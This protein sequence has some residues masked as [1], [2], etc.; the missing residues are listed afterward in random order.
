MPDTGG[1]LILDP[2]DR[3]EPIVK[4]R[5]ALT[6]TGKSGK[7]NVIGWFTEC[8]GLTIE[9]EP[10]PYKEGG[11]NDFEHQ[12]PG[13]VKQSRVTLKRGLA[14][15]SLWDWFQ[16]GLY[17][18]KVERRNVSIILYNSDLTKKKQWDLDSA[19]PVKWTGPDFQ[20]DTNQ[21][22]VETLELVHH[23]LSMKDWAA[24]EA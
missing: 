1:V 20:S 24:T 15:N 5:F 23:G 13:R 12:L 9:R 11:V 18:G 8:N 6:M 21:V 19:F 3:I 16:E 22:A 7:V 14:D 10:I 2:S 4:F 17:D